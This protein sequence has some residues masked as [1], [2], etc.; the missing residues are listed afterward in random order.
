MFNSMRFVKQGSRWFLLMVITVVAVCLLAPYSISSSYA[1]GK[2]SN[3]KKPVTIQPEKVMELLEDYEQ[4]YVAMLLLNK[5]NPVEQIIPR[6]DAPDY[7]SYVDVVGY[8]HLIRGEY[9]KAEKVYDLAIKKQEQLFGRDHPRY[10]Q[11]VA[12]SLVVYK[13]RSDEE[14]AAQ[15][16]KMAEASLENSL[17]KP[18]EERLKVLLRL[19]E[20]NYPPEKD[21]WRY[22][23]MII[24]TAKELYGENDVRYA[25]F[26]ARLTRH[27]VFVMSDPEEV[28]KVFLPAMEIRKAVYG[29]KSPEYVRSLIYLSYIYT[30]EMNSKKVQELYKRKDYKAANDLVQTKR[31]LS[32]QA[33]KKAW[34]LYQGT[35]GLKKDVVYLQVVKKKLEM[36]AMAGK[37]KDDKPLVDEAI[38]LSESLYH[39]KNPNITGLL[40]YFVPPGDPSYLIQQYE[41]NLKINERVF[42]EYSAYTA[43]AR[44]ML[45]SA[46]LSSYYQSKKES[47]FEEGV[48][49]YEIYLSNLKR[50]VG[51]SNTRYTSALQVYAQYWAQK[52]KQ[53]AAQILQSAEDL[54]NKTVKK[55]TVEYA[56]SLQ[57][58]AG[59]YMNIEYNYAKA[60]EL[61]EE[62][63]RIYEKVLGKDND[64]SQGIRNMLIHVYKEMGEYGKVLPM[65]EADVAGKD[66]SVS[67]I[68]SL[69]EVYTYLGERDKVRNLMSLVEK[70]MKGMQSLELSTAQEAMGDYYLAEGQYK[71]SRKYY[72]DALKTLEVGFPGIDLSK[73]DFGTTK[74]FGQARAAQGMK[75]YTAAEKLYK[76]SIA[77]DMSGYK[78]TLGLADFYRLTGRYEEAVTTINKALDGV[79]ERKGKS[80]PESASVFIQAGIIYGE[81]GKP[82]EAFDN[83][84]KSLITLNAFID[85]LSLWS[86]EARLQSYLAT[87]DQ[88]Y[89]YFYSLLS[90]Y[91]P[92]EDEA[93]KAMEVHLLY[94]GRVADI[95]AT[96]NRLGLISTNTDL[97]QTIE[98]YK[99]L[100]QQ[101]SHLSLN[102]PANLDAS[103][104][105]ELMGKLDGK[106]QGLEERLARGSA[107][108]AE[109][110]KLKDIS[111]DAVA[112][113]LPDG[114]IYLDLVEYRKYDYVKKQMTDE[115]HYLAFMLQRDA[116]DRAVVRI[117]DLGSADKIDS[118]VSTLRKEF[119]QE[120]AI[121]RGIG[122]KRIAG[123]AEKA[124]KAGKLPDASIQLYE[125]V[126]SPFK[127]ELAKANV[128]F[129]AP[130][131]NLNLIPFE[132]LSVP[133]RKGYLCD[134][135]PVIYTLGR[136]LFTAKL[137]NEEMQGEKGSRQITVVAAP[138]F[139]L[140]KSKGMKVASAKTFEPVRVL[141]RGS[142]QGWP[143][144]F[145]ALPG[146]LEEAEAIRKIA[147][148]GATKFYIK[149]NALEENVK[150]LKHP[151]VLHLATHGF[152][153]ED[154]HSSVQEGTRGIGGVRTTKKDT[155][156]Q[157]VVLKG[158]VELHDP[159][160]RSGLALTG[161]NCLAENTAIPEGNEDGILTAAEVTGMDLYG[162]NLV[163]LS[164]CETGLGEIQRGNGVAGLRRSFKIAGAENIV[165]SL[166]SVPDQE[167]GWLMEEFYRSYLAGDNPAVALNK[168]RSALR[169]KLTARDGIDQPFYWAAFI[170]EGTTM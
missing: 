13:S 93:K 63:N 118:I 94:K 78:H 101:I 54:K 114:S 135:I 132:A 41:E 26:I 117:E 24:S 123:K 21:P 1:S 33:V 53:K 83:E 133:D 44:T 70:K 68:L 15:Y 14:S 87:I 134:Q 138:D 3:E 8:Y 23:Q 38:A 151:R 12:M 29:E 51:E 37:V 48:K 36:D 142:V 5:L 76:Q 61:F 96:R 84:S 55:D 119:E 92:S 90:N 125:K 16:A 152:F 100:M 67:Q 57:A 116:S 28:E 167:T 137:K 111:A 75:D 153:L 60:A 169:R 98:E 168:A 147:G 45:A 170:L 9:D 110:Q 64:M 166:W 112:A 95:L 163:V 154:A 146:T 139:S 149:D 22:P 58:L 17:K 105:K 2:Q 107:E 81:W 18:S 130:S 86:S 109:K 10:V 113:S 50:Q 103:K 65:C 88:R 126:L 115:R 150:N 25:N 129:L 136:D 7:L 62:S 145:G 122:G 106:K 34:S 6:G 30:L 131:G 162:T 72:E 80:H 164:A 39:E 79:M 69:V 46:Y 32:D 47:D 155:A 42:G 71:V 161:A 35:D 140:K 11:S 108:Y 82:K 27:I 160:I 97:S 59:N 40:M 99:D 91:H 4:H 77:S 20:F 127:N 85:K 159:L 158:P 156:V 73:M 143:I 74:Y 19:I 165:M 66:P 52:D 128:L 56:A 31:N 120:K 148:D 144:K 104:Y 121:D 89:D 141:S 124:G 49:H 157:P 102:P 43:G